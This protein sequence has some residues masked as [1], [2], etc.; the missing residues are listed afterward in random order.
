[1]NMEL[2]PPDLLL[3]Q[4]QSRLAAIN[5]IIF[6]KDNNLKNSPEGKLRVDKRGGSL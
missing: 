1:M 6:A 4:L 2:L 3:P 5:A